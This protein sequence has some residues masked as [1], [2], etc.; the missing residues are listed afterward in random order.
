[1][2]L[3]PRLAGLY[4]IGVGVIV[5][6]GMQRLT[7]DRALAL[8]LEHNPQLQVA[9]A[10]REGAEAGV[11]TARAYPNPELTTMTGQQF[12]RPNR[13]FGGA[14]PGLLQHYSVHQPIEL[15]SVRSARI[16][17]AQAGRE[18]SGHALREAR[19]A[20][21]A[22]VKQAFFQVLRRRNE[23]TL[24]SENLRL[25]EDLRRRIQVQV[26]V[27]EAARLELIRADS[28]VATAR[29]LATSAQ[30][31]YTNAVAY[32]RTVV[33]A[34]L[35][36]NVELEGQLETRQPL[37]A[38]ETLREEVVSRH[39]SLSQAQAEIRRAESRLRTEQALRRPSPTVH[40][41]YEHQPDLQFYRFGV[42]LPMPIWNKR[43]GPI[44]EAAAG[45]RQAN[46][47]ADLRRLEINANLERA[48]G[49][50]EVATQQ[51]VSFEDG[52]LLEA[53]A[54]VKAAE[55]AYRFGERGIIDVLDAQRVLRTVRLDYLS[56]Q[57]D[58]QT[59]IIEIEQL[60]AVDPEQK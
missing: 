48:Y 12:T 21:R 6:Q 59:A 9:S 46:A 47:L 42:S 23:I 28:E 43:E 22:M 34:P 29:T 10:L 15:P 60:R 33:G 5:A 56:A 51:L 35:G 40:S 17:T 13:I 11:L 52:V 38:L 36:P 8:A 18:S 45:L 41:E 24:A 31:R 49:L 26:E 27:G 39:P 53:D 58:L 30:L 57:Y 19:L 14:A 3:L 1:M 20:V 25:I 4:V 37:P 54:A 7:L 50:Y 16:R 2:R 32:F 44:G 55:A